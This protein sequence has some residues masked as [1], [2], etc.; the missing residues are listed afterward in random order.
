ML[1]EQIVRCEQLR[2][3]AKSQIEHAAFDRAAA[4]YKVLAS[5]LE[6]AIEQEEAANMKVADEVRT[7]FLPNIAADSHRLMQLMKRTRPTRTTRSEWP[8]HH[9]ER[10]RG[11]SEQVCCS[12]GGR[13]LDG[14][15]SGAQGTG[16]DRN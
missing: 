3:A 5:V 2:D 12:D 14:L 16:A 6:S 8:R 11:E 13:W 1:R 4:H 10:E 15:R 9:G 7:D